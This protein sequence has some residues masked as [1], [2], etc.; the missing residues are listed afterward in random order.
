MPLRL[1]IKRKLVQRSERVKSVE[2][3]PSEPWVLANLYSGNVFIWNHATNA[4]VKSFEVTEL[5]V[6]TARFV[7]RKQWVVAGADDM[8]IRAYNYNTGEL[9][10]GFEAHGDYI[11]ALAV[12]PTLP[13]LL[14]SSDDM[15]IKLWDWEKGWACAQVFE[16]HSHYVMAVCFNPKDSNTF[17][18]AS[19]D[20]TVKV[21]S[22]GQAVPNFTLEGHEKGVNCVDYFAGGDRPFLAS[23]ADDRLVKIWDY[24]TKTCVQTLEGHSHNVSAVA[25]HPELPLILSGS[26]DGTLRLWH[27]TT[28]RLEN[29]LNYGLERAWALA[30]MKGSN[31]VAVGY[32]E[33]TVIFKV[34][35]EEPVASMDASGKIIWARHSEIQTVNVRSLPADYEPVDGERLPLSVKDLGSCELYPQSLSHGPNGRFVAVCGD[36]EHIIYTALA[37]RNK[38]FGPA[39]DIVWSADAAEYAVRESASKIVLFRNFAERRQLRPAFTAEGLHG[40]PQSHAGRRHSVDAGDPVAGPD[41]RQPC[42]AAGQR[43]LHDQIATRGVDREFHADTAELLGDVIEMIEVGGAIEAGVGP[44][45]PACRQKCRVGIEF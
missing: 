7:V 38:S 42:R 27:S 24:Q 13:Y 22:L 6:R 44:P 41:P 17:A 36:G 21:W 29:T 14:S 10:K 4:A 19:L 28:Y 32:D 15:L 11:R 12:H 9:V 16:G 8:F 2:L 45:L 1:D 25:F 30:V 35:R 39:L 18:S 26:E 37:W 31:D 33:G 43:R 20:R 40:V 23:G 5:P 3:H 34:G